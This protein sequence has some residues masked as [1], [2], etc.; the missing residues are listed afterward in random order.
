MAKLYWYKSCQHCGQGRLF[1][2]LDT[3]NDNIYLHCEECEWGWRD[4]ENLNT[5][6]GFLTIDENFDAIPAIMDDI[7]RFS[8]E[9]YA[10]EIA[11]E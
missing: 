6:A 2:Y 1:L 4:P 7:I 9:K 8:W 5:E 10:K 11:D 3:T